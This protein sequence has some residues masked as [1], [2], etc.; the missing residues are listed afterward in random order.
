MMWA[1]A[2]A[3]RCESWAFREDIE[4]LRGGAGLGRWFGAQVV[5]CLAVDVEE[6]RYALYWP[7]EAR[8]HILC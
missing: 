5:V 8:E 6:Q 3:M 1:R 4:A 2:A 7:K